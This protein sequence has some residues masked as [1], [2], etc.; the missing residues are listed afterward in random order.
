MNHTVHIIATSTMAPTGNF[1]KNDIA[2]EV[3]NVAYRVPITHICII[4]GLESLAI[5]YTL[6]AICGNKK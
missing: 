1:N 4:F 3:G 5:M 2:H 6:C